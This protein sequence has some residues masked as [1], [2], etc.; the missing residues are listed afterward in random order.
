MDEIPGSAIRAVFF[1]IDGTLVSFKNHTMPESTQKALHALRERGIRVYVATG[2]SKTLVSFLD[3]YFIFDAYLTLNGQ[4][5]YDRDGAI[6]KVAIDAADIIRLKELLEERPFPCLFVDE[7]GI[8][9]NYVNEDVRE[10]CRIID[11]SVPQVAGPERVKEGGIFQF[12]PFLDDDGAKILESA[13][14]H[15]EI[16][17]SVPMCF[18]VLPA[19]GGKDAGM[20]AVLQKAGISMRETMAFGDSFNDIGMLCAAG[21]GVAMGNAHDA[22]KAKADFVTKSVDEDGILHALRHFGILD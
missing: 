12:V 17:R 19:G 20:E 22:V 8:F 5:C 9:L 2:R 16:T 3:A 1:D 11:C 6:R 4:Y 15:V 7:E 10:L 21:I 13:L 18:D 14:E